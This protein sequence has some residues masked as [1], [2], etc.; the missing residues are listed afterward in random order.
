MFLLMFV[1]LF[2]IGVVERNLYF[3]EDAGLLNLFGSRIL[4]F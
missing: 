2:L 3:V 4:V 1:V